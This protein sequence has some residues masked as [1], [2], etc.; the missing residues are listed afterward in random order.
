MDN[1]N[2]ENKQKYRLIKNQKNQLKV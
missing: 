2:V 1:R